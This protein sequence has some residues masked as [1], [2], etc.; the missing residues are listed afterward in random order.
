[1]VMNFAVTE[2]PLRISEEQD[3]P[4][5]EF[6]FVSKDN[7]SFLAIPTLFKIFWVALENM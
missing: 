5:C 3:F 6:A 2:N 1:M 4:A 7:W